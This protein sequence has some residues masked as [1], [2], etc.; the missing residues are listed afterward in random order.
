[1]NRH[2]IRTGLLAAALLLSSAATRAEDTVSLDFVNTD[3]AAVAKAVGFITGRNFILDP[4]VKGT[5]NIVSS[6]PVPKSQV[7]DVFLSTLRTQGYTAVQGRGVMKIVP[8][9]DAKQNV[10]ATSGKN[11]KS[12][13][14]A[15]V[16]QVY[17]LQFADATQ[18]LPALRP[19]I[20]PNNVI[21]A[22]ADGNVLVMTDYAD[23]LKRINKLIEA[24]DRPAGRDTEMIKLKHAVAVDVAALL[25]KVLGDGQQTSASQRLFLAADARSN[26]ILMRSDNPSRMERV[27]QMVAQLDTPDSLAA[28][29]KV[30]Y[31]RNANAV[32]LVQTLRGMLSTD[33]SSSTSSTATSTATASAPSASAANA[34]TA[35]ASLSGG[36]IQFLAD[37][38]SN[39]IILVG[40]GV[41]QAQYAQVIEK[42]DTRPAQVFVEALIV[43]MSASKIKELGIQWQ[44]LDGLGKNTTQAFGG[45]NFGSTGSNILAA[46]QNIAGVGRGI[47]I[48]VM[49]GTVTVPIGGKDVE[50]V[51]LGLLARALEAKEGVNI[52][53]APNLLTLDNEEAKIVIGK[54]VPFVTGQYTVTSSTN[55]TSPFQT[56]ERQDVGL[57]LRVKPQISENGN[58]RLKL[59]Q[60]VS[61]VTKDPNV[62]GLVTNKRSI[63]TNVVVD[64]S[65]VVVLGGLMEDSYSNGEDKVP[66]LGDIPVMGRLFRSDT[67]NQTKTNLFIFLRPTVVRDSKGLETLSNARYEYVKGRFGSDLDRS[68]MAVDEPLENQLWLKPAVVAPAEPA[69]SA[70]Q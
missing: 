32:K 64:D 42:L 7:Y 15:M 51:N 25:Q 35:G 30:I 36:Q 22:L 65:R 62:D 8:E 55:T 48:G 59:Y 60:E 61:T 3:I 31:L 43:E 33:T 41:L 6:K 45:T 4:R 66:L 67:Q 19:L 20:S 57:T 10:T 23:N 63:D 27:R 53:S 29:T 11:L 13:G 50:I 26:T 54:N 68:G 2:A 28:Q 1:M 58:I 40:P 46:S 56:I 18:M 37:A 34:Q 12:S 21:S 9:T 24:M 69:S 17:P 16:T 44:F 14:D 47:N 49:D 38:A 39:A 52:L 5:V 70:G